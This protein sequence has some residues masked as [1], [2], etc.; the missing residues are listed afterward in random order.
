MGWSVL[1]EDEM[2][3]DLSMDWSLKE[4]RSADFGMWSPSRVRICFVPSI[5]VGNEDCFLTRT[6]R[7]QEAFSR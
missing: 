4:E 7:D 5:R 6:F 2:R 1:D 3:E